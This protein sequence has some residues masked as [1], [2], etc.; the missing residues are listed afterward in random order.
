M[1]SLNPAFS[2]KC[3]RQ[4]NWCWAAV[5][6]GVKEYPP[7]QTPAPQCDIATNA[8]PG[9]QDCCAAPNP[10]DIEFSLRT[11]LSGEGK[12]FQFLN[13]QISF[14]DLQQEIDVFNQPVCA[15]IVWDEDGDGFGEGAHFVVIVGC[16]DPGPGGVPWVSVKDPDGGAAG[17]AGPI[18]SN[19]YE[20]SFADFRSRYRLIGTWLQ[21]YRVK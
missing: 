9:G 14:S 6:A 13:S 11:A 7:L 12:L 3:Q 16:Q 17:F 4:R 20:M 8:L 5:T 21:T 2:M 19:L 18:E 1:G 15:R 10:C